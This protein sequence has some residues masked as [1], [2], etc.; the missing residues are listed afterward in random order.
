PPVLEEFEFES[1]LDTP[2]R[3]SQAIMVQMNSG[4]REA[5][6]RFAPVSGAVTAEANYRTY[7]DG[8]PDQWASMTEAGR[9]SAYVAQNLTG[10]KV[11]FRVRFANN[12]GEVSY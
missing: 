2:A 6:V 8:L 1:N 3:P 5:R 10:Q 7:T 9:I 4:Q 11:D 12:D